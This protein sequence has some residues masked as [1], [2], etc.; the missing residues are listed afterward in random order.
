[1]VQSN[2]EIVVK[3]EDTGGG[4]DPVVVDRLFEPFITTSQ[5]KDSE[6]GIGTG[7]GLKIVADIAD[8]YGGSVSLVEPSP[9]FQTAFE[10]RVPVW[11]GE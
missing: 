2:G 10:F 8:A 6:L 1:M 3:F 4:V 9:G 11:T 7:L 5:A